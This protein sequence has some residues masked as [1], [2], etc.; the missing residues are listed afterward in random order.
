MGFDEYCL[1][2]WHEDLWYYQ[3]YLWQNGKRRTDI[4]D[5]YGP[6]IM[7]QYLMDFIERNKSTPFFA[8]YSLEL[9]HAATNDL[10]KPAPVGPNGRYDSYSEMVG[11][12]DERLGRV[13]AAIDRLQL[14]NKTL[15]VFSAGNGTAAH[16]LVGVM[17][18]S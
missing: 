1:D 6:D 5:R 17:A 3:P 11:K 13:L 16:N 14:R 7:C 10:E 4:C 12:M 9:C 8:F 18:T 15:V 2:G